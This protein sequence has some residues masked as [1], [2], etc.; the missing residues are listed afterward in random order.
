M[1]S[2]ESVYNFSNNLFTGCKPIKTG[3]LKLD[4]WVI[5]LDFSCV[6]ECLRVSLE[7]MCKQ[8]KSKNAQLLVRK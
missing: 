2:I 5:A 4:F 7:G 8:C 1:E 6:N 3:K